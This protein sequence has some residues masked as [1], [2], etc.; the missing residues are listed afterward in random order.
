MTAESIHNG[1]S[2]GPMLARWLQLAGASVLLALASACKPAEKA[3]PAS[4]ASGITGYNFTSEG[5]QAFYV[6]GQWGSNLPPYGGGGGTTCCINLPKHW[7]P[8]LVVKIDWTIG[9]Y[10]LTS[11]QTA[12]MT[13]EEI[14]AC[15]WSQRAL[16]TTVPIERYGTEG[17]ALQVFFL[18]NDEINVWVSDYDLGHEQHPSGMA[19]PKNPEPQA[20]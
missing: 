20:Q 2:R 14:R 8:G 11:P 7:R 19:Y 6:N 4:Y 5:V 16:S 17:G 10:T 18:P 3:E 9:H 1:W 12:S 13:T 15:C